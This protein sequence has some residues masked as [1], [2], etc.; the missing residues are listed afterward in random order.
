MEEP[1]VRVTTAEDLRIPPTPDSPSLIRSTMST[2]KSP[3]ESSDDCD[4]PELKCAICLG[5]LRNKSLIDSCFHE[6]CFEC[7][8]EWS[9]V[10]PECPLCKTKFEY[11]IHNVKSNDDYEKYH[12]QNNQQDTDLQIPWME[13]PNRSFRYRT[14]MTPQLQERLAVQHIVAIRER[15]SG[16]T[17]R[18][19][20]RWYHRRPQNIPEFRS[21]VYRENLWVQPLSD[22]T[23]RFRECSPSFYRENPAQVYRL[24]RW[25]QRELLVLLPLNCPHRTFVMQTIINNVFQHPIRSPFFS[26]Q[27]QPYL[28]ANTRHFIHEFAEYARSPFDMGG[29]D[30]AATYLP[31]GPAAIEEVVLNSPTN[32]EVSDANL[33]DLLNSSGSD[34]EI[35]ESGAPPPAPV[36]GPSGVRR[37]RAPRVKMNKRA[38]PILPLSNEETH[39]IISSSSSSDECEV[40]GTFKPPTPEVIDILSDDDEGSP[41]SS[42]PNG[43]GAQQR[44]MDHPEETVDLHSEQTPDVTN[45]GYLDMSA[46]RPRLIVKIESGRIKRKA[47]KKRRRRDSSSS[48]GRSSSESSERGGWSGARSKWKWSDSDSNYDPGGES[49]GRIPSVVVPQPSFKIKPSS[50]S[51][52]VVEE[53]VKDEGNGERESDDGRRE[54][55]RERCRKRKKSKH[56]K[57]HKRSHRAAGEDEDWGEGTSGSGGGRRCKMCRHK[58]CRCNHGALLSSHKRIKNHHRETTE[59]RESASGSSRSRSK[60]KRHSKFK[61]S[62]SKCSDSSGE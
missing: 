19:R 50:S 24:V 29:H 44:F 61:Y 47:K 32:S 13:D 14:T 5:R 4:T 46:D 38:N 10:K 18:P 45:P 53:V 40:I 48:W 41:R 26:T 52:L 12:C 20:S 3:S 7:L 36:A 33:D 8:V 43:N 1:S 2:P 11:I 21:R 42:P 54:H 35:I 51:R 30:R 62:D 37:P 60:S 59:E 16:I 9:K 6:F 28:G 57:K 49:R 15:S 56:S 22:V 34:I 25:L 23:N 39:E 58:R 27:L 55:G 31:H 17:A